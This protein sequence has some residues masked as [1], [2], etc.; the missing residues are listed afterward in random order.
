M[1]DLVKR[2]NTYRFKSDGRRQEPMPQIGKGE[3]L[4]PGAYSYEDFSQR[5]KKMNLTYSF[6]NHSPIDKSR[7]GM[8]SV[9]YVLLF[10]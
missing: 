3:S 9:T 2:P 8:E 1:N 6:K 4:L 7:F 5:V 10:Y